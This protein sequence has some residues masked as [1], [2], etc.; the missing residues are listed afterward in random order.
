MEVLVVM[1]LVLSTIAIISALGTA[2]SRLSQPKQVD[3]AAFVP[4][5]WNIPEAH[6]AAIYKA[7]RAYLKPDNTD[8]ERIAYFLELRRAGF[9]AFGHGHWE[10]DRTGGFPYGRLVEKNPN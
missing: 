2:L 9:D 1:S 3:K 7:R 6:Q 10:F 8:M 4:R 5:T